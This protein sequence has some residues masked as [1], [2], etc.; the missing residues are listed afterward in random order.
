MQF[1]QTLRDIFGGY[2]EGGVSIFLD[3]NALSHDFIPDNAIHRDTEIRQLANIIAPALRGAKISNVFLYGKT[4]TGK[5]L[6][7]RQVTSE[8]ERQARN[9]KALYINCK[10][11]KVSDTEYRLFAELS[12]MMGKDVPPTGLPTDH[13]YKIFYNTI[14][15]LGGTVILVLDE[16]D[17]L[18][19]KIGDE[20]LYNLTRANQ[21]LENSRISII[22]ISNNITFIET[23]DPRVK[24]TL[25]EEEM[26]FPPY[27]ATQLKDILQQRAKAAFSPGT[28]GPGVIE[29]C[30]ALAAQEHGDARK[31]LDLLRVASEMAERKKEPR[32]MV[33]HVDM[34][35]DK[36]DLDRAYEMVRAQP[37]QSQ[38]VLAAIIRL[39]DAGHKNTRTGDIFSMYET[40]CTKASLKPL[41]Q[42]RVSGLIRGATAEPGK[43]H[44]S[45]P[46]MPREK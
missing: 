35:E 29:K 36:I 20:I 2:A 19:N 15:E 37:K 28:L 8:L 18:V 33:A 26:I 1:Q 10:M 46:R 42:R 17:V 38:A 40:I 5:T 6:V 3:R 43:Y 11:K 21:Y 44:S 12:R 27:N 22:G 7:A 14:E 34:A 39:S 9:V 16:I 25:S 45:S 13:I 24:S 41:T 30:A 31:A 32:V 4:G 23:L